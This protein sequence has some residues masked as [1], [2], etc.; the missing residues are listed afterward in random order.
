[1]K[2][3]SISGSLRE[4]V[5][6][7]DAKAQRNSGMIPCVLYGGKEQFQFVVSEEQFRKLLYTPEVKYAELTINDKKFE[8]IV[9][10]TQ[11]HPITDK[12]L[13]V[14][15]LEVVEGKPIE[16]G[17][18][19][20]VTGTSPGVL[21]GGKLSKKVRKL[22]VKGELKDIPEN[23]IVDISNMD[24]N[25]SIKVNNLTIANLQFMEVPTKIIVSVA[26]TRNVEAAEEEA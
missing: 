10:A 22:K 12:L 24:I 23:I 21:R 3:V 6:K 16:I 18:P 13:H 1:M 17:I 14:D 11:F 15:F 4:N 26:S 19:V 8:A 25:D 9:Q 7:K 20:K 5:G 2:S